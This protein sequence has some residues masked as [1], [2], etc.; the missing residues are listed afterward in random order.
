[1]GISIININTDIKEPTHAYH[2]T[3]LIL[4]LDGYICRGKRVFEPYLFAS[5]PSSTIL[6]LRRFHVRCEGS[7][8][9]YGP[10][11]S[12]RNLVWVE[13]QCGSHSFHYEN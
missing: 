5:I 2:N 1:M 7:C 3:I 12:T 8:M 9:V 10:E 4:T 13:N 6:I 11:C